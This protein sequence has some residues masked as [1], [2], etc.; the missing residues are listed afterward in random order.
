MHIHV[1]VPAQLSA[2]SSFVCQSSLLSMTSHQTRKRRTRHQSSKELGNNSTVDAT[3]K[4]KMRDDDDDHEME[5]VITPRV[6]PE[7]STSCKSML[8]LVQ[9]GRSGDTYLSNEAQSHFT[10]PLSNNGTILPLSHVDSALNDGIFYR[11]VDYPQS[12]VEKLNLDDSKICV[13]SNAF[14]PRLFCIARHDVPMFFLDKH[15]GFLCGATNPKEAVNKLGKQ[16]AD[17]KGGSTIQ[18]YQGSYTVTEITPSSFE[19]DNSFRL[20]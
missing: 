8:W 11:A 13:E 10:A 19:P 14:H 4:S 1:S 6:N 7:E 5:I 18:Y 17:R 15:Q 12:P 20:P 9:L 16:L 3:K 2:I